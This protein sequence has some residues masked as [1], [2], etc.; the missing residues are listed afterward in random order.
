MFGAI[1]HQAAFVGRRSISRSF[2]TVGAQIP[3]V[4][5]HKNWPVEK[6]NIREHCKHKN[7]VIVGLPAAFTPTWSNKQIPD[8]KEKQDALRA[9]GV[10][11]V[12]ILAVN[13]G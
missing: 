2:A 9:K 10:Q 1:A 11:E 6:I 13:D 4:E 5:L 7:V 3:S 8:Y 12:I